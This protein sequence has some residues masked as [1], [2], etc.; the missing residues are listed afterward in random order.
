MKNIMITAAL[1]FF[2]IAAVAQNVTHAEYFI[3][4]DAGFGNNTIVPI[5]N[6]QPHGTYDFQVNLTGVNIGYHKLYVRTKDSNG[7]WSFT[8]RRNIEVTASTNIKDLVIGEYFFDSDPGFNAATPI[9]LSLPDSVILQAFTANTTNL[10]TGYH[11]LYTRI[12]DNEGKWS[13][14]SRR[15]I[16]IF[17]SLPPEITGAEYFFNTD[18]GT[19]NATQFSFTNPQANGSFDFKIPITN[20]PAGSH[21]LYIR[22]KENTSNKYSL[23][24]WQADSIIT[25]VQAG[26][27]SNINTWANKKIPA[28]N[29]IILLYHNVM[30]DMD[31]TCKSLTPYGSV[32]T[33]TILAGKKLIITGR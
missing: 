9:N 24:Q 15:N 10:T 17:N 1:I 16:E 11:K 25:T 8:S 27:W 22:A 5:S 3:D 30:L 7:K 18:P 14:T 29:A 23:L 21:T 28:G 33:A 13:L 4:A 12:K 20:I 26:L 31:A 6:P 2:Q 32:V 19:G